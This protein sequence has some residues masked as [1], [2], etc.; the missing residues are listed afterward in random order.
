MA[1]GLSLHIGLNR[2]D[3]R[4]YEGWDGALTACEFDARDMRDIARSRGFRPTLLLTRRATYGNIVRE[5]RRAAEALHRGDIFFLSYSGHGGQVKDLNGD[6]RE[7][8][9]D[10]TWVLYDREMIDDELYALWGGFEQGVRVVV[11]SDSCHSGTVTRMRAYRRLPAPAGARLKAIPADVQQRT[12]ARHRALYERIQ[13]NLPRGE[14]V[15]IGASILLLSGCQENQ[16]SADGDRNGLFTEVLRK[17]WN[18]GKFRGSYRSLHQA[19][20]RRMPPWQSPN[21]FR[22]GVPNTAFELEPPFT[23]AP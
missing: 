3:P 12:F 7:D 6:E 19:I 23:V 14:R 21:F 9:L 1:T 4:H 18:G 15:A 10:E 16:L 5:I 17:V 22:T 8:R 2:V 20:A 13:R 11:L